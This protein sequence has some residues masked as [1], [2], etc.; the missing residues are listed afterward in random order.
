MSVLVLETLAA[1]VLQW[2]AARRVLHCEPG[3][4]SQPRALRKAL[5]EVR[6]LI[7]PPWVV[8]DAQ[9]LRHAPMLRAVGCVGAGTDHVDLAACERAGVQVLRS[10]TAA[11][12]AEAEFII[13]T[14]LLL[15]RR[16]PVP[17]PDGL[18]VGRELQGSSVGLI[19]MAPVARRVAGLLAAFGAQVLGYDPA[20][21]ASD[22]R[23]QA[24]GVEPAGLHE[25]LQRCDAVSVQLQPFSRYRGLMGERLLPWCKPDQVIVSI[26][27]AA[28]F[29]EQA[30]ADA[31]RSRR[32]SAA[33][34]DSVAP[35]ALEPGR[36]LAGLSTLQ[37]SVT[38]RHDGIL[39]CH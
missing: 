27:D 11:A 16:V 30:L 13:A 4:A 2:L 37:V 31:L 12:P 14:L 36:P 39:R 23:W 22:M 32:I 33:W 7:V 35:G 19:G 6:G 26:A 9:A 1:D 28:L 15:L 10:A 5:R 3:L 8:L 24:W 17:T 18:W 34:L 29:D 21:H 38:L 20:L 25:L